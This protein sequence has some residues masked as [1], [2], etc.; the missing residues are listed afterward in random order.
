[1]ISKALGNPVRLQILAHL[2]RGE[3]YI[4]QLV[5]ELGV[6]QQ[7]VFRHLKFLEDAGLVHSSMRQYEEYKGEVT[8]PSRRRKYYSIDHT[9]SINFDV[10]PFLFFQ[11]VTL[12]SEETLADLPDEMKVEIA[13]IDQIE[14][15]PEHFLQL[16]EKSLFLEEQNADLVAKKHVLL[17]QR[18]YIQE[19]VKRILNKLFTNPTEQEI[20]YRL[21]SRDFHSVDEL[22]RHLDVHPETIELVVSK[23]KEHINY[24][25]LV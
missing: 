8:P 23:L 9:L 6:P 7:I 18:H 5:N 4:L 22:A 11:D 2:A 10:G 24:E 1:L 17:A 12:L 21:F 14:D 19:R 13:E 16:Y 15:K 20:A 25:F 3:R